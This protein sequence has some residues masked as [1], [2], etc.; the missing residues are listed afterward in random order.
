MNFI[1]HCRD[2]K[3]QMECEEEWFSE[4][5]KMTR[6]FCSED[7]FASLIGQICS[8]RNTAVE[9]RNKT[10]WCCASRSDWVLWKKSPP[11]NNMQA[12]IWTCLIGPVWKQILKFPGAGSMIHIIHCF[13]CEVYIQ[14]SVCDGSHV[15][16]GFWGESITCFQTPESQ[17]FWAF[18]NCILK[19]TS[20]V[21]RRTFTKVLKY[22]IINW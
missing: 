8:C 22:S 16:H 12:S 3:T 17:E 20:C 14:V 10:A 7:V 11:A 5:N 13:L 15:K 19:T 2:C 1:F 9:K 6:A 21:N 18:Y 4:A